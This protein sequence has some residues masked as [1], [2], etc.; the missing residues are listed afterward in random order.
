MTIS[1]NN[2]T[3]ETCPICYGDYTN[4]EREDTDKVVELACHHFQH[5]D[6]VANWFTENENNNRDLSCGYCNQIL[7]PKREPLH[8][9]LEGLEAYFSRIERDPYQGSNREVIRCLEELRPRSESILNLLMNIISLNQLTETGKTEFRNW[10]LTNIQPQ[11]RYISGK[12]IGEFLN[13]GGA[14][15]TLREEIRDLSYISPKNW[16]IP[17]EGI[18]VLNCTSDGVEFRMKVS[19]EYFERAAKAYIYRKK[20]NIPDFD[21]IHNLAKFEESLGYITRKYSYDSKVVGCFQDAK[22]LRENISKLIQSNCSLPTEEIVALIKEMIITSGVS[23]N[24]KTT[25]PLIINEILFD[26]GAL[27]TLSE[28]VDRW[29]KEAVEKWPSTFRENGIEFLDKDNLVQYCNIKYFK[30]LV[31]SKLVN[32]RVSSITKLF[33]AGVVAGLVVRNIL[34]E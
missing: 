26:R 3:Y 9:T 6:C 16:F 25:I 17:E 22:K 29:K 1:L 8:L 4:S 12:I 31:N 2:S 27:R 14:L 13:R 15:R 11:L 20:H 19:K 18:A 23:D 34:A 24:L 7:M 30:E 32:D 5:I 10:L 28:E 33:F 21:R